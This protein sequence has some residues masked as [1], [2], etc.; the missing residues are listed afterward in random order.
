MSGNDIVKMEDVKPVPKR[1]IEEFDR[2]NVMLQISHEHCCVE[3]TALQARFTD[4]LTVKEQPYKREIKVDDKWTRLN[5]GCWLEKDQIGYV[6][7]V[8]NTGRASLVNPTAK[9][10]KATKKV[11][12]ELAV[13]AELVHTPFARCR[14]GGRPAFLDVVD[15]S[16]IYIRSAK[17]TTAEVTVLA[18]PG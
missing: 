15:M 9:E 5:K 1:E 8:N 11:I 14:P 6:V 2:L 7:V 17:G 3:P 18:F 16:S 12:V 13:Y 4:L 10:K